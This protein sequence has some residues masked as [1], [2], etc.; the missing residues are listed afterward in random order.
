MDAING[1]LEYEDTAGLSFV[2]TSA[3][4]RPVVQRR[5]RSGTEQRLRI[6][7]AANRWLVRAEDELTL[8]QAI[9]TLIAGK[10]GYPVAWVTLCDPQNPRLGRPVAWSSEGAASFWPARDA[11]PGAWQGSGLVDGL[12][13]SGRHCA[14]PLAVA[15][16]ALEPWRDEALRCGY[17]TVAALPLT[18]HGRLVGS[19]VV[20]GIGPSG[21]GNG[22]I[23]LLRDIAELLS[24]GTAALQD[25][26]DLDASLNK[27]HGSLESTVAGIAR[28]AEA[29]DPYTA[30]HQRRTA[31]L[32]AAIARQ[33]KLPEQQLEGVRLAGLIHDVGKA[34]MPVENLLW[35]G[36]LSP[37]QFEVI[38]AHC[39][40]CYDIIKGFDLPWPIAQTI[41]QHHERL[42]GSG[43]PA[44]LSG[45]RVLLE[46][47]IV[48]VADVVEAMT[49]CRPYRP[50]LGIEVAMDE[51]A[52]GRGRLYDPAV[53]DA[54][55]AVLLS[56]AFGD[57]AS[58]LPCAKAAIGRGEK[59][60]RVRRPA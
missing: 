25:R 54:C 40:I 7:A 53:V 4:D 43:Y 56:G 35:P 49:A 14:F 48:A 18:V 57:P 19:L 1:C 33:M 52:S 28:M 50:A 42:D 60:A 17:G 36:R 59:P 24:Y 9:C 55:A 30:D 31:S 3:D 23:G 51:V 38:K 8:M 34:G 10:G 2:I 47:R 21:L 27:L 26:A 16:P 20:L 6:L 37:A 44:G 15:H 45:E 46:A 29:F 41:L 13:L 12:S 5:G 32:A 11:R 58:H 39:K 22:D